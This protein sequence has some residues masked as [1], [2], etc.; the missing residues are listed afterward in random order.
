MNNAIGFK[1]TFH[2]YYS[3]GI[4]LN[5]TTPSELYEFMKNQSSGIPQAVVGDF[6]VFPD[7]VCRLSGGHKPTLTLFLVSGG[8]DQVPHWQSFIL[9]YEWRLNRCLATLPW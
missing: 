4:N 6:N 7:H 5:S 2:T 8:S 3:S 9:W 1:L